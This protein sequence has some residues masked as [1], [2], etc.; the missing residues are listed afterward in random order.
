VAVYSSCERVSL[1]LN[2]RKIGEKPTT[3]A[4]KYRAEFD[5]PYEPG[6]LAARGEMAGKPPVE[7][8]L[9]TAKRPAALR[10][11]A[12]RTSI[13]AGRDDLCYALVEL[14]DADGTLVPE[15]RP[16][17]RAFVTGAG[18]IAAMANADPVDVAS[19]RGP[20]RKVYQGVCQVILRPNGWPGTIALTV[21]SEGL[22][23]ATLMVT[24]K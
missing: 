16:I 5:V 14:V 4:E 12:D 1:T 9:R 2:G 3:R 6:E 10:L 18:E 15:E 19:Y 21:A 13:R 23:P 20:S 24:A 17:V 7:A 11:S 22:P 8:K